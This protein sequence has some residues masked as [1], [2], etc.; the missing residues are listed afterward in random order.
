MT[1]AE[2][3]SIGEREVIS[4]VGA[5]GKT[6]LLYALAGNSRRFTLGSS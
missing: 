4:L 1:L 3:F 6:T 2:A 5:G